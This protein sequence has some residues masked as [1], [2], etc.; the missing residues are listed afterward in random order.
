LGVNLGFCTSI[1]DIT[2]MV[3][4]TKSSLYSHYKGKDEVLLAVSE[5]VFNQHGR[6]FERL[7][8]ESKTFEI[9]QRLRFNFGE[10][11]LYFYRNN[12]IYNFSNQTLLHLPPELFKQ[13]RSD[14]LIWEKQY[15]NRLEDMFKEGM[16]T[17]IICKGD[18]I[19]KVWSFKAK[20][21][22]ALGW[23]CASPELTEESIDDFWNDFWLG[24]EVRK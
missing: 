12:V 8:E 24:V 2:D 16:E 1:S 3:G 10:Y 6:L 5:D 13:L 4:I 19:K 17:G 15:R 20:R 14:Y 11:I 18:P 21:D 22:G 23:I 7:I 9:K